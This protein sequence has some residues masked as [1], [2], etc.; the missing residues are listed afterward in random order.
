MWRVYRWILALFCLFFSACSSQS[1]KFQEIEPGSIYKGEITINEPSSS[2][3]VVLSNGQIEIDASNT[4]DG[5]IMVRTLQPFDAKLK[6]RIQLGSD[7]YTY[8]LPSDMEYSVFPLQMGNGEY[9]ITFYQNIQDNKYAQIYSEDLSVQQKQE[10]RVFVFPNQF[11]WYTHEY[12]AILLSYDLCDGLE[13]DQ[14]KIDAIYNYLIQY[15]DYDNEK[16]ANVQAGYIPNLE[17]VLQEKKGICFDYAALMAAMLRAQNI[18]TR[19]VMGDL[20]SEGIY[21]AWNQVEIDGEW[22]WYDPTYGKNN[23]NKTE[24]YIEDRRY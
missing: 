5:Y 22:T 6:C 24:D 8:T 2:N 10:D 1:T 20:S 7:Q 15:M 16:A 21:H 23:K 17:Q 19:L 3:E 11:V 9:T 4:S 12:P 18:P 13:G 14:E